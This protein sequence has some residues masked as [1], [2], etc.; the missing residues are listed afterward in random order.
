ML[1]IK[2]KSRLVLPYGSRIKKWE[3]EIA[4]SVLILLP[5]KIYIVIYANDLFVIISQTR[6]LTETI[7]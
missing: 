5:P 2:F 7:H 4:L 1:R 6:S 3:V